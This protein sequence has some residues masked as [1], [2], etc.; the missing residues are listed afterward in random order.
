MI[1][2]KVIYTDGHQVTVTDSEFHVKNA[3]YKL[4]GL[5]N[6]GL[7]VV[8][9]SPLPTI[10][11]ILIGLALIGLGFAKLVPS[12]MIKDVTIGG[13]LVSANTMAMAVGGFLALIGV[14]T[15]GL[16]R[17]R[18]AL[19][20]STAEGERN[21]LVSPKKEYIS[22]IVEAITSAYNNAAFHSSSYNVLRTDN[23]S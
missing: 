21:V 11:L 6:H 12:D 22:Q 23:L 13:T 9:P 3:N 4:N 20:I 1:P 2:D 10:V 5:I 17:E 19:R 16:L 15:I 14:L 18:Y 8:R 7:Y